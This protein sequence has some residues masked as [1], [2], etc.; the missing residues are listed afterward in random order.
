MKAGGFKELLV[1]QQSMELTDFVYAICRKLPKEEIYGIG[2]QLRRACA[3]I[4]SNLAEGSGHGSKK[5]FVQ[6]LRIAYGSL[7][8]VE[9]QILIIERQQ[10]IQHNWKIVNEKISSIGRLLKAL[11]QSLK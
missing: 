9:T 2:L 8:E 3:S 11:I 7:C 4:P 5:E 1:W 10:L 6:F